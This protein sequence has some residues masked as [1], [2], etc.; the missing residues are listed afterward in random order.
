MISQSAK[1]KVKSVTQTGSKD[2]NE[3]FYTPNW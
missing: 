1:G 2:I 3:E